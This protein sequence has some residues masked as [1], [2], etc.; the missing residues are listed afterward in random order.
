M[1][2]TEPGSNPQIA[3]RSELRQGLRQRYL[4]AGI[5]IFLIITACILYSLTRQQDAKATTK[6]VFAIN[7][8]TDV[9]AD[10]INAEIS[11]QDNVC[12]LTWNGEFPEGSLFMIERSENEKWQL[13]QKA[14]KEEV[15]IRENSFRFRDEEAESGLVTYRISCLNAEGK[16]LTSSEV[17]TEAH[18]ITEQLLTITAI[19][20]LPFNDQFTISL[21]AEKEELISFEI[22]DNSNNIVYSE[23]YN[24]KKGDNLIGFTRGQQLMKGVYIVRLSGSDESTAMT[25]LIKQ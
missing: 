23:V 3:L 21:E 1:K 16:T 24:V 10:D 20:P 9:A 7:N 15:M 13:V 2:T 8:A 12:V 5:S 25:K 17:Q 22:L 14:P 4:Y 11:I 6:P 18:L 19:E